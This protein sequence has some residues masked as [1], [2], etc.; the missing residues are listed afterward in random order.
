M[1][2]PSDAH[3]YNLLEKSIKSVRNP[4]LSLRIYKSQQNEFNINTLL[5]ES[6]LQ[7]LVCIHCSSSNLPWIIKID[8]SSFMGAPDCIHRQPFF[9][10]CH[11]ELPVSW[12]NYTVKFW[13]RF[14]YNPYD[15]R[16]TPVSNLNGWKS[17]KLTDIPYRL[18]CMMLNAI[19][20]RCLH[21]F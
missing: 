1:S 7:S 14:V 20:P 13:A 3:L 11:L 19:G 8:Q 12:C 15:F 6:S 16:C 17:V 18:T 2:T 21:N 4:D 9:S 5:T 10:F